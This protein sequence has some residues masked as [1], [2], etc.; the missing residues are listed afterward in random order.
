MAQTGA[1]NPLAAPR[2]FPY[3]QMQV[4]RAAN[5][6][7][8]RVA[9]RGTLATGEAVAAHESTQPAG[10]TPSPLHR[11]QHSEVIVVEQGTVEFDHDGK[12]EKAGPGSMI[13]VAYGTLHRLKNVGD[14]P[15]KYAVIQIG[16][17]TKK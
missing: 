4:H 1:A 11:I 7:E 12:A 14:G 2:V 10:A 15:A 16:G 17:D 6:A 5:G 13:Y 8:S 9:F 3:S